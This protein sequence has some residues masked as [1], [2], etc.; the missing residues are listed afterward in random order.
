MADDPVC[1]AELHLASLLN[2]WSIA[3]TISRHRATVDRP[4]VVSQ[5]QDVQAL[6]FWEA[7][8]FRAHPFWLRMEDN[9]T[10]SDQSL[11]VPTQR[12]MHTRFIASFCS[13]LGVT[14]E[15]VLPFITVVRPALAF[16]RVLGM[17]ANDVPLTDVSEQDRSGLEHIWRR[18]LAFAEY[19]RAQHPDASRLA[20]YIDLAAARAAR[21]VAEFE[22]LSKWVQGLQNGTFRPTPGLH[23]E[24]TQGALIT[25]DAW[26]RE[27]NKC[28][29]SSAIYILRQ[30]M[31]SCEVQ[32]DGG[33]RKRMDRLLGIDE[34]AS[35]TPTSPLNLK[36]VRAAWEQESVR[37]MKA[38]SSAVFRALHAGLFQPTNA[39]G[40]KYAAVDPVTLLEQL[41]L[42][43]LEAVVG[44]NNRFFGA[45][46]HKARYCGC[47]G[48]HLGG[49]MDL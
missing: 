35:Y 18:R 30:V 46:I 24:G 43:V 47:C 39:E 4:E 37:L 16:L 38:D 12:L 23:R 5:S 11:L 27:R 1:T 44:Q 41:M 28:S 8:Q 34:G 45:Q 31:C 10:G 40:T 29:L 21:H 48:G 19:C 22:L 25:T 13:M 32:M 14:V 26:D 17:L 15:V 36:A 9:P 3:E 6:M 42:P 20:V 33:A 7:N 2:G 49:G